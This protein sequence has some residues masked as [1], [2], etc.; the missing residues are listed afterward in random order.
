MGNRNNRAKAPVLN[1]L[2]I[3]IYSIE[4]F[5]RYVLIGGG[6]G[7]EIANKI[8]VY[9]V[10]ANTQILTKQV[11]E[12][13]TGNTVPNYMQCAKDGLNLVAVCLTENVALFKIEPKTGKLIKLI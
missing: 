1:R 6:G 7:Y 5:E 13:I 3:P 4:Y 10:E 9:E 8:I 11:H 2:K 12:E